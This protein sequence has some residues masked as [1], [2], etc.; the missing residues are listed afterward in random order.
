MK[1]PRSASQ[2]SE[3]FLLLLLMYPLLSVGRPKHVK[4]MAGG[5]EGSTFIGPTA[6]VG[7]A[8][9]NYVYLFII[10]SIEVF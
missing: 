10:R 6:E 4:V 7:G 1:I 3:F 8:L 5:L 2:A 9:I